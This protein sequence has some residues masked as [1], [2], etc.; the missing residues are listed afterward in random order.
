MDTEGERMNQLQPHQQ[1]VVVE[2]DELAEK[3]SKLTSFIGSTTYAG[4]PEDE[5]FDLCDQVNCMHSYRS[6]LDRRIDRFHGIKKYKSLKCVQARPMTRGAY[7]ELQGWTI[8]PDEDP[9]DEG[10][11]VE[12]LDG[13]KPNHKDFAN[14][15]SWSPKDVFDRNHKET[16]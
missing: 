7:N 14:Y 13:G 9:K 6:V 8:P 10:Y 16:M 4:L 12:Y 2:R 1:R 5:R 15:I 11:L 3:L